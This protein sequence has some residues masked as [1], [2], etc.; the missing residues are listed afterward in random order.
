MPTGPLESVKDLGSGG[1]SGGK[2]HGYR[3]DGSPEGLMAALA[4]EVADV[5]MMDVGEVAPG[6]KLDDYGLEAWSRSSCATGP[7][8]SRA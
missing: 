7:S 2:A 5:T 6:R 3:K 1:G 8:A 4:G